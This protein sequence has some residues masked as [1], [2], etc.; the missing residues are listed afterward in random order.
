MQESEHSSDLHA[1]QVLQQAHS[2]M[3]QIMQQVRDTAVTHMT[4]QT[5]LAK[6][7]PLPRGMRL[8]QGLVL[9]GLRD[10]GCEHMNAWSNN[11]LPLNQDQH[12]PDAADGLIVRQVRDGLSS[13]NDLLHVSIHLAGQLRWKHVSKEGLPHSGCKWKFWAGIRQT[14][15]QLCLL[16]LAKPQQIMCAVVFV[17]PILDACVDKAKVTIGGPAATTVGITYV[18]PRSRASRAT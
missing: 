8:M 3:K 11:S 17:A 7:W 12:T 13:L 15:C 1:H 9:Q 5:A 10:H 16:Q 2:D 4:K 14:T 6:L 18:Q